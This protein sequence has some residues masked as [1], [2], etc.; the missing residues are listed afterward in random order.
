[1]GLHNKTI[2][3]GSKATQIAAG[4]FLF[5]LHFATQE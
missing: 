1:M 3:F 5:D 2:F 4:K